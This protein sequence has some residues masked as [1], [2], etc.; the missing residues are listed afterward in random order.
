MRNKLLF[1][2]DLGQF[3]AFRIIGDEHSIQPR[4]TLLESFVP[5]GSHGKMSNKLTDEAG[6]FR[7]GTPG[8]SVPASGERHNITLEFERRTILMLADQIEQICRREPELPFIY[9]AAHKEINNQLI[10]RLPA[11][12]QANIIRNVL[13]DLTKVPQTELLDHFLHAE[14]TAGIGH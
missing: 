3:K 14:T 1:V 6:R 2:M 9:L 10:E 8:T 7:G 13:E 5:I 11:D 4:V 12:L